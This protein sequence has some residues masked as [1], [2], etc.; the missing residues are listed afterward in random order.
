M[1]AHIGLSKHTLI[2]KERKMH[3][4]LP[5]KG[6]KVQLLAGEERESALTIAEEGREAQSKL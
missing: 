6:D 2:N 3:S 1:L 4:W 5:G